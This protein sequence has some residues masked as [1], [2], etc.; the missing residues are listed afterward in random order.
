[1][2][3]LPSGLPVGFT[4]GALAGYRQHTVHGRLNPFWEFDR[5]IS[6]QAEVGRTIADIL[7]DAPDVPSWFWLA[8]EVRINGKRLNRELWDFTRPK[9]HR[10]DCPVI[11][12]LHPAYQGGGGGGSTKNVITTVAAIALV[13]GAV[14][15]SGGLLGPAAAG[16]I[17]TG[18]FG[19]AFA[20]GGI[21]ANLVAAGLSLSAAA[22]LAVA[23]VAP[24]PQANDTG[25]QQTSNAGI[26]QNPLRPM[27][28]LPVILGRIRYSPPLIAPPYTTLESGI[29][30]VHAVFGLAGHY[31]IETDEILL[32]AVPID[33]F[34]EAEYQVRTGS[35]DDAALT[36]CDQTVIERRNQNAMLTNF[37]LGA[38][39]TEQDTLVHQSNPDQDLP[40]W[41]IFKTAGTADE[42]RLRFFWPAIQ[43][44]G[45]APSTSFVPL[46]IEIREHGASTWLKMPTVHVRSFRL[47]EQVRKEVRL[48]FANTGGDRVNDDPDQNVY[49]VYYETGSGESFEYTAES[50]FANTA[51]VDTI[52]VMTSG[53]TSGVTMSADTTAGGGFEAWRAGDNNVEVYWA[54][55]TGALPHWL[56]VNFGAANNKTIKS[57]RIHDANVT[58]F[59]LRSW[60]LEGSNDDSAWTVLDTR[61]DV[62]D[63]GTSSIAGPLYHWYQVT[64]PGSYRYYRVNVTAKN[65]AGNQVII[66]DLILS[67]GDAQGSN[68]DSIF[69][70]HVNIIDDGVEMFLDPAT[71]PKGEYEVRVK[72]GWAGAND[73]FDK[74]S[75]VYNGSAVTAS[76]FD[77]FSD[78][79]TH[80]IRQNQGTTTSETFLESFATVS[81]DYPF[82]ASIHQKGV[83]MIAVRAPSVTLESLSAIF[84][85]I[86]PVWS[87]GNDWSVDA[88]SSNPAA[89]ARHVLLSTEQ[90]A[91]ALPGEL[92]NEE[93]FIEFFQQCVDESHEY[94]GVVDGMSVIEVYRQVLAAGYGAPDWPGTWSV[95]WEYDRSAETPVQLFTPLDTRGLTVSLSL[96]KLPHAFR[97]IFQDEDDD[98]NVN[99]G[100]LVYID[101][102]SADTATRI[103]ELNLPGWTNAAKVAE[104]ALFDL[105]QLYLRKRR[106]A[107][108]IGLAGLEARR[109]DLVILRH[110]V[111][112]RYHDFSRIK[113]IQK[114]GGNITGLT[115]ESEVDLSIAVGEVEENMAAVIQFTD[116]STG[117]HQVNEKVLT[118]VVTFTTPFADPDDGVTDEDEFLMRV[119]MSVGFGVV[120]TEEENMVVLWYEYVD[121]LTR[122]LTLVDEARGLHA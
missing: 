53:T 109:G 19:S 92:L 110:D 22:L 89:L 91:E 85:S 5:P 65:G 11:I 76:F 86:V 57:Y 38:K 23:A 121:E 74:D 80:K 50:Y 78:G 40:Q 36:I 118:D 29:L 90:N 64:S 45:T 101:G 27:Q 51:P 28:T 112:S 12:T 61:T 62:T 79:G 35:D 47:G 98:Y 116:R 94:N 55:S 21:G 26:S 71:F 13:A 119:G 41:Q 44:G 106:F 99:E 100:S 95:I 97:P 117:T 66:G 58:G 88:T 60:T 111:V 2:R 108:E 67:E 4:N 54:S 16:G 56:K 3:T 37:V 120:N 77:H 39:Q 103:E 72:R 82:H 8:G 25:T 9:L 1:M 83:A 32:N 102:Q 24:A 96:A 105:R 49:A 17:G 122:R 75:Y 70:S 87:A 73:D 115:F 14:L 33:D 30:Y 20:A 114:S 31:D 59:S 15:V 48:I 63:W 107:F 93:A 10:P 43:N 81:D 113:S 34:D 68:T 104:R 6:F 7:R 69:A 52:P 46:R 42:I 84:H 18:L